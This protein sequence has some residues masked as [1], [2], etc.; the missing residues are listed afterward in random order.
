MCAIRGLN[1]F[2]QLAGSQQNGREESGNYRNL[3]TSTNMQQHCELGWG[4][5]YRNSQEIKKHVP[6]FDLFGRSRD[7]FLPI[8]IHFGTR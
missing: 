2:W 8:L 1:L 5:T 6:E 4:K 3:R 7:H